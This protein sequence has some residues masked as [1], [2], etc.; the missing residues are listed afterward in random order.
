M[1]PARGICSQSRVRY[2]SEKVQQKL[3]VLTIF[4]HAKFIF[5]Y[6]SK[7]HVYGLKFVVKFYLQYHKR[8]KRNFHF[9]PFSFSRINEYLHGGSV[10]SAPINMVVYLFREIEQ[11]FY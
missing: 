9:L 5:I 1:A 7:L 6:L 8:T 2:I 3:Y 4:E 10:W 11:Y